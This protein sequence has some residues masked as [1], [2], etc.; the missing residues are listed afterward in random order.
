MKKE[1]ILAIIIG[2]LLGF[3][4]MGIFWT[5]N[6][7]GFE[8][9]SKETIENEQTE[10]TKLKEN[11]EVSP[12]QSI[13]SEISLNLTN[14]ENES[15]V[16]NAKINVTGETSPLATVVIIWEEGE[17]ILVADEQGVFETE[18]GLIG[19]PNEIEITA[20]SESGKF[21]KENLI[22]TYSTAKF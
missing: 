22:I 1:V 15:V 21:I 20:Y 19:G 5:N 8:N 10:E 17:D 9:L 13:S 12:A 11:L 14:P 4:I 18:I 2:A 3:G 16:T 7:N 6:N